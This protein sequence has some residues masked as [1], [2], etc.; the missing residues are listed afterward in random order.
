MVEVVIVIVIDVTVDGDAVRGMLK[1]LLEILYISQFIS[2]G[3][4]V[5]RHI[6]C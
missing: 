5:I 4:V 6:E 1:C 3:D 2:V